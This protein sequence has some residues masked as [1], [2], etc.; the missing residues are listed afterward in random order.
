MKRKLYS[1]PNQIQLR[2]AMLILKLPK[3]LK[4]SLE[5]EAKDANLSIKAH[6]INKLDRVTPTAEY[7][8][9]SSLVNGLPVLVNY[10]ES[11]PGV[12]ILSSEV[13]SDCYWWVKLDIELENKYS[14]H[15][16]QELG[17][18][19]NYIS[20]EEPM[21]TVFKPVSPPPYMNGGPN[22]CLSWVIESTFNYIDPVWVKETLEGRLPN[23]VTE[24]SQWG[25]Y[26]NV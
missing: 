22:K 2:E 6:I 17:F 25:M 20:L 5:K 15:V 21:P 9:K 23:P 24:L 10:L 13:T 14:W 18:V 8:D 11:I 12:S 4:K 3:E 19:L 7:I 16:V 26:D 1:D